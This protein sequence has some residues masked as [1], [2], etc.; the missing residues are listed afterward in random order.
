MR[1]NNYLQNE[2]LSSL[3]DKGEEKAVKRIINRIESVNDREE[4]EN[5]IKI[6]PMEKIKSSKSKKNIKDAYSEKRK[7]LGPIRS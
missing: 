2:S 3:F 6:I 1:F 5:L 7:E 4:L